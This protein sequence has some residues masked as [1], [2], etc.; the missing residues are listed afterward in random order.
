MYLETFPN[1][2][3]AINLYEKFN[4]QYINYPMGNTGH[5]YCTTRMLLN[6]KTHGV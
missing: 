2:K 4:F 5:F 6:L 3:E 1:M